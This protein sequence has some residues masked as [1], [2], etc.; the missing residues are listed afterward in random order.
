MLFKKGLSFPFLAQTQNFK[1][2]LKTLKDFFFSLFLSL[3][4]LI[5][6]DSAKDVEEAGALPKLPV[7]GA[8]G[9]EGV[10]Q[11][12]NKECPPLDSA[13]ARAESCEPEKAAS[14]D[15]A[16][17]VEENDTEVNCENEGSPSVS[18]SESAL[19]LGKAEAAPSEVSA[20]EPKKIMYSQIVREGRRFNIDLVSKVGTY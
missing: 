14:V 19:D 15:T 4:F 11:D 5:S 17:T 6:Q 9:A 16:S 1:Q 2:D 20:Q 7:F 3:V 10:A 12:P 8:S 13:V 18:S